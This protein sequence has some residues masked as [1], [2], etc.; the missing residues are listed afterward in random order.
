M[1]IECKVY[2]DCSCDSPAEGSV[3]GNR[4][5]LEELWLWTVCGRSHVYDEHNGQRE[6]TPDDEE[7]SRAW[8]LQIFTGPGKDCTT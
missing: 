7:I 1:Y 6:Y 5:V 2:G 4:G 3:Y 8:T